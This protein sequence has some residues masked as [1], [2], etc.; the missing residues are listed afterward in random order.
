MSA[1]LPVF[2]LEEL[3]AV[4]RVDLAHFTKEDAYELG[5]I[6]VG[7]IKEMGVNLAVD[8]VID[9][10]LVFRA[11]LGTT[12]KGNDQWLAGKAA[13]ARHFGAPSLLVRLRQ[14]ATGVPFT[15]LDL[16]HDTVKGHGGSIPLFVDGALVATITMS[17][18]PD[19]VDHKANAEAVRRYLAQVAA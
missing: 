4:P 8:I 2:T 6:A 3:E 10:D 15:D 9:D 16:D 1:E 12:G 14:E 18:E 19:V 17:G 7:V 13:A 11:K 5:T